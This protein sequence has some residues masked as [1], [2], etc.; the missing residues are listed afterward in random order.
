MLSEFFVNSDESA[1]K[2]NITNLIEF[3]KVELRLVLEG[4]SVDDVFNLSE[5]RRLKGNGA[6]G[7]RIPASVPPFHDHVQELRLERARIR[8]K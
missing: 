3:Y 2:Q 4:A 8:G 7:S 5:Q 1:Q 6:R